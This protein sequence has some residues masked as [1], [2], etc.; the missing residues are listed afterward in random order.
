MFSTIQIVFNAGWPITMLDVLVGE[1][2]AIT[3]ADIDELATTHGPQ[4]DFAVELLRFRYHGSEKSGR[5]AGAVLFDPLAV[6]VAID[7]SFLRT[8]DM[9]VDIETR[10]EFTRGETVANRT[11]TLENDVWNGDR[12]AAAGLERVRPNVSVGVGVDAGSTSGAFSR[13]GGSKGG[14]FLNGHIAVRPGDWGGEDC[15]IPGR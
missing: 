2:A 11:G 10:G 9:R 14:F 6:A 5:P 4:N 15:T 7:P 1:Q 8:Q 13:P 12:Y 3:K